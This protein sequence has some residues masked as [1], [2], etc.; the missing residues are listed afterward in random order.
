MTCAFLL[1]AATDAEL[2]QR[3]SAG[4]AGMVVAFVGAVVALWL[5]LR[6]LGRRARSEEE[7]QRLEGAFR[8]IDEE[9]RRDRAAG[10]R[11]PPARRG[12]I[13]RVGKEG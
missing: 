1:A 7:E 12:A 6:A 4:R 9:L 8:E 13:P 10:S 11:P 3:M 5:G 2:A